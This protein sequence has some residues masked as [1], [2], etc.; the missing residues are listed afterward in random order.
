MNR[1][2]RSSLLL[3]FLLFLSLTGPAW[4][5]V[6]KEQKPVPEPKAAKEQQASASMPTI[7]LGN[8]AY[9]SKDRR[10]P[11]EAIYLQRLKKEPSSRGQKS[12]YEL[13]ELKVVGTLK[14]GAVT[15]VMMEDKQGKGLLFKKGDHINNNLWVTNILENKMVMAYKLRGDLRKIEMDIPRKQER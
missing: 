1:H 4:P 8:F 14:T 9:T 5:Q 12:G 3:V 13:E 15:F 6:A 2:P 7:D 10:D 11:F